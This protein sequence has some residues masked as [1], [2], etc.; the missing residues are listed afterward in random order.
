MKP[1]TR[2]V[3]T[4]RDAGVLDHIVAAWHGHDEYLMRKV[5]S[6]AQTEGLAT[7]GTVLE[8]LLVDLARRVC[9]TFL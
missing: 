3:T 6:H 7:A 9:V 4:M 8:G 2:L 1:G 5:Y